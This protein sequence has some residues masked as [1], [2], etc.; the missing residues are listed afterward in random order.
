MM[1]YLM[2]MFTKVYGALKKLEGIN[3]IYS[4]INLPALPSNLEIGSKISE[5]VVESDP[6]E[7]KNTNNEIGDGN[8]MVRKVA[9]D[10]EAELYKNLSLRRWHLAQSY[11]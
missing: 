7:D 9:K 6:N 10:E 4:E 8:A 5:H 3:P 1:G 2:D 11:A